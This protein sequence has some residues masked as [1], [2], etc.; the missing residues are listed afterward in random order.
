VVGRTSGFD[1]SDSIKL[2]LKRTGLSLR[3]V[4]VSAR[5]Q[6]LFY[7]DGYTYALKVC[8][9]GL[10]PPLPIARSGVLCDCDCHAGSQRPPCCAGPRSLAA[11][12]NPHTTSA[13]NL[14]ASRHPTNHHATMMAPGYAA[15]FIDEMAEQAGDCY[16]VAI[17]SSA[18]QNP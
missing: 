8:C 5:T 13:P 9:S 7:H 2:W 1:W 15:V 11:R 4:L 6:W 12:L 18:T 17:C 14:D 10:D 16:R 3:R